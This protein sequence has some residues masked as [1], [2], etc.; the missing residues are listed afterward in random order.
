M[1]L[2]TIFRTIG[3]WGAGKGAN[4]TPAE[5]DGNFYELKTAIEDL[6]DNPP[7]AVGVANITGDG[8][9]L[10]IFLEDS[11]TFGPFP[12]PTATPIVPVGTIASPTY[13]LLLAD[14]GKYLRCTGTGD[15][16]GIGCVVSIPIDDELLIPIGAEYYFRQASDG[17]IAFDSGDTGSTVTIN[18]V[19]GFENATGLP[20]ATVMLKKVGADEWDL[21]GGL[22]QATP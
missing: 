22:L 1:S 9:N 13:T 16:D 11:T 15:T 21:V 7:S 12:L 20:G 3:A 4:L 17:G 10:T 5:V 6:Q 8:A 14:R 2:S 18:G 19:A